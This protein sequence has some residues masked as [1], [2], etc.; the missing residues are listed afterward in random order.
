[1]R[2]P[3]KALEAIERLVGGDFGMEMEWYAHFHAKDRDIHWLKTNLRIASRLIS[4][5]YCISHAENSKGCKHEDWEKIKYDIL[6]K[7]EV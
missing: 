2:N 6:A 1:M 4:E 7:E 5:I 3:H